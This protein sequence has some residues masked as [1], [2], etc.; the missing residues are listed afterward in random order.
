MH[1][2]RFT[3]MAISSNVTHIVL[4]AALDVSSAAYETPKVKWSA[5]T[6]YFE[7]P[8][9]PH[10]TVTIS[11]EETRDIQAM[12]NV[13][14][15]TKLMSM[16]KLTLVNFKDDKILEDLDMSFLN[17]PRTSK[18][19]GTFDFIPPDNFLGSHVTWRYETFMDYLDTQIT[20]MLQVLNDENVTISI[21]GRPELIRKITPKEYSYVTP[22]NIG[23]VML[24]Y[25]KTV[26][27]SDNRV[28]QF[29]SSNKLRNDNNLII[30]LNPRNSNRIMYKIFDYQLYV[31]NEIRDT[32]NYQLPAV[33]AFE[34]FL[35]I[36]Y[37]PV[38]GRIQILNPTGLKTQ[39]END[40]PIGN[41]ALNDW[42]AN[43][44]TYDRE[45]KKYVEFGDASIPKTPK[46]VMNRMVAAPGEFRDAVYGNTDYAYAPDYATSDPSRPAPKNNTT[47]YWN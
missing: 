47:G 36:S 42:T 1:N 35:F 43:Q 44:I 19:T 39:V 2:N 24:D 13:N 26:K 29:I 5:R 28:Y 30:I 37:Q 38:Q 40:A 3:F 7:I 45:A 31:G 15:L 25:K 14:Q 34:R 20:T 18:V 46:S 23:P 8:E 17:L 21:F 16:I 10:I 33:T 22:S 4:S 9:A 41:R 32:D 6:D 11:P 27:T 12:Y